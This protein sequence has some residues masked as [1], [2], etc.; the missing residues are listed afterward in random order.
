MCNQ[1]TTGFNFGQGACGYNTTGCG[2]NTCGRQQWICRD[3]CG[4]IWVNQQRRSCGCGGCG[5]LCGN[6]ANNVGSTQN[7][8]GQTGR[9]TCVTFCGVNNTQTTNN[10]DLYYARQ[11]G[12]YP[13]GYN[14]G[15][16]CTL[17]AVS[18]T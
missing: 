16:G 18:E 13:Y 10:G 3:C 5:N 14:G 12:L 1:Y 4:N 9:F 17:D 8:N 11:Y 2:Y 6:N 15:C 7:G